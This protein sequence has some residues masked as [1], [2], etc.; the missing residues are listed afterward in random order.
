MG[1]RCRGLTG[2]RPHAADRTAQY[3]R[4]AAANRARF[5]LQPSRVGW[6]VL[7]G[8]STVDPDVAWRR[9]V[10]GAV[11][12]L[13]PD[14]ADGLLDSMRFVESLEPWVDVDPDDPELVAG[15][16]EAIEA[17]GVRTLEMEDAAGNLHAPAGTPTGGQ[18]TA[19][20][21][22]GKSTGGRSGS[23]TRPPRRGAG[24]GT[25]SYDGRSGTGYGRPGG[26]ARVKDLQQA[27]NRLGLKDRNGKPLAVDG[28]LGP[29]TDSAVKA[30][31]KALGV[32]QD[33]KVT[34]EM[35]S[36][37]KGMKTLPSGSR[38]KESDE[39]E[40]VTEAVDH[41]DSGRV[42]EA[43]GTDEAG[44][45]VFRVRIIEAGTSRNKKEYTERILR[46]HRAM[47]LGAKSYDRHRSMEELR[48]STISGLVGGYRNVSYDRDGLYADL[49]LL[50][51]ATHTAEALDASI[52]AQNQGLPPLVGLSHDVVAK[53]GP[54]RRDGVQEAVAITRVHSVDVVAD[55]S[56][57]G[58]AE[59]VLAGGIEDDPAGAGDR[60]TEGED[61][62]VN[63]TD[64]LA[65]L[66]TATPDELAAVGLARA[67][68]HTTEGQRPSATGQ[69]TVEADDTDEYGRDT[70]HGRSLVREKLRA[71]GLER[72]T[73]AITNALPERITEADVDRQ[74]GLYQSVLAETER[75]GLRPTAGT[76]VTKDV[77]DRQSERLDKF[78]SQDFTSGYRSLRHAYMDI[79]GYRP[80]FDYDEDVNRRILRESFGGGYDS[81][82]RTTESVDTSTWAQVLGDSVTR[83]VVAAYQVPGL[84]AWRRVVSSIVPVDDFRTQRVGRVG[85]YG[86]LPTVLEGGPYQP[87]TTPPDEEATYALSK[88]GGTEDVTLEQIAND[89][90][91]VIPQI[92]SK[93]GRAAAQTLYRFVFDFFV[94]NPATTYDSV[95]WF[96]SSHG[97]T[98]SAALSQSALT[99]ASVA[100][101][102]QT[103][104]GDASEVLG[105]PASIL[106]VPS[107]LRELA[108]QLTRSAV[109]VP[110]T[111]AG[112]SDTPNIHSAEDNITYICLPYWTDAN[113]WVAIADPQA[114]PTLEVGFYQGRQVPE[115]F[116]QADSSSGSVFNADVFTW[117][118]RFIFSGTILD[119]RGVYKGTQ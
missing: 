60:T 73:E 16:R 31:Q 35:L 71:A 107:E 19:G 29:L 7:H 24:S 111:P 58:R 11:A 1:Q 59:R 20:G 42:L 78:F 91:R 89:D 96:H 80:S 101:M 69:R 61:V 72:V 81:G 46:A 100:L 48:S 3:P 49:H 30:A 82:I 113:D 104:Y 119:H 52:E 6:L 28:K 87:L 12:T 15:V 108:F 23:S 110:S 63:K 32:A 2:W 65:A 27:L 34:P 83:R 93:L 40:R 118:I 94:N 79:T 56:A 66:S 97:N 41:I 115:I 57:G 86:V 85:G 53:F 37:L 70:W 84:Q 8:R 68:T 26:D 18:F 76:H 98:A 75:A 50:P 13:A 112:P 44:G 102:E 22:G 17:Q 4:R 38:A 55:P 67:G 105:H 43:R 25:L 62:P 103:A 14:D 9:A 109:A 74:I 51:G 10:E 77:R 117:K 116:T 36:R 5:T 39:G 47:Y 33:G 92:P 54:P 106:L 95:A 114:V 88:K 64:V 45:R 90:R 99:A 21:S